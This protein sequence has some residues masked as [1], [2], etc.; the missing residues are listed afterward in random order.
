[1]ETSVAAADDWCR[2]MCGAAMN[3]V[4][5]EIWKRSQKLNILNMIYT[6][7]AGGL[8]SV[9][10]LLQMNE[11]ERLQCATFEKKRKSAPHRRYHTA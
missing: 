4:Q 6:F 1:M 7:F 9:G 2:T 11:F 3:A 5:Y 10:A 8:R